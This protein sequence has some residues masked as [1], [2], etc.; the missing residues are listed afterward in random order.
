MP[1][2]LTRKQKQADTRSRLMRSAAKVFCRKGMAGGS[3]DEVAQDAG[4][5]KGAFYANFKS[6]EELFLAMLDERFAQRLEEINRV[7]TA[8]G[9]L[10]EQAREAG[11]DAFLLKPLAEHTLVGTVQRLLEARSARIERCTSKE[12]AR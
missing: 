7:A 1:R 3:I 10:E 2:R 6:K 5:T 12:N 11:A 9:G 8:G 4:Y